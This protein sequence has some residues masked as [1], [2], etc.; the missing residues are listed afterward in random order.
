MNPIR[1]L[2]IALLCLIPAIASALVWE[3]DSVEKKAT[4]DDEQVVGDFVFRNDTNTPVTILGFQPACDCVTVSSTN[5]V[6]QPGQRGVARAVFRVGQRDGNQRVTINALTDEKGKTAKAL[7]F[8][9]KLPKLYELDPH[10]LWWKIGDKPDPKFARIR[11]PPGSPMTIDAVE[12]AN[13]R[14]ITAELLPRAANGDYLIRITPVST[15]ATTTAI[16]YITTNFPP[17]KPKHINMLAEVLEHAPPL[18]P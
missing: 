12:S 17:K 9:I 14:A 6:I 11:I 3:N 16:I 7:E 10:Y 4:Y 8:I 18:L 13:I 15:A 5:G 2:P 1:L